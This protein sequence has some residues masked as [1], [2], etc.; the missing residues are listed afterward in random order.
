MKWD[1]SKLTEAL[2]AFSAGF[3]PDTPRERRR[4]KIIQAA[5]EL[6]T[7]QGFRKTSIGEVARRAGVAKGTIYLYVKTKADLL[8]QAIVE[9]KRRYIT[10]LRPLYEEPL[11]PRQRLKRYLE[12]ALCIS[13]EMPLVSR[14]MGGDR[15]ILLVL[16]EMDP[17]ER[18]RTLAMQHDFFIEMVD[19]AARP[20]RWTATELEDRARVLLGLMYAAGAF[21]DARLRGGLSLERFA[22]ILAGVIVEGVAG[23]SP[24]VAV[25]PGAPR[26]A[27]GGGTP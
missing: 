11:S 4:Q 1:Y 19:L 15:E 12:M 24:E 6:F 20:H 5:T 9:E 17:E 8:I 22:E 18:G 14:L 7:K 26:P 10:R 23:G 25:H 13:A 2:E 21:A 16:E 3:D 27:G